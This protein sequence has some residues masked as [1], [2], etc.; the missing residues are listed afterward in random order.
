VAVEYGFSLVTGLTVHHWGRRSVRCLARHLA[1]HPAHRPCHD[2]DDV[3]ASLD[4]SSMVVPASQR[5]NRFQ[6]GVLQDPTAL[7]AQVNVHAL[8]LG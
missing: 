4:R 5:S 2:R 6:R 8:P 3:D 1:R 7:L